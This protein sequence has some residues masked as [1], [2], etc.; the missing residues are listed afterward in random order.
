MPVKS[1]C[2]V[3]PAYLS[4]FEPVNSNLPKMAC[5]NTGCHLKILLCLA[6]DGQVEPGKKG[7]FDS[8]YIPTALRLL[9]L[10]HCSCCTNCLK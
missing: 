4:R 7:R 8:G 5:Y 6:G 1:D 10:V 2:Q 9:S 3:K